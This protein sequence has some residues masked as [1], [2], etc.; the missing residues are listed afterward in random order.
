MYQ[1]RIFFN[2]KD[3]AERFGSVTSLAMCY[4]TIIQNYFVGL[5]LATICLLFVYLCYVQITQCLPNC[6]LLSSVNEDNKYSDNLV[7]FTAQNCDR[8]K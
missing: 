7:D 2:S 6:L 1:G 5:H 4:T 8:I 3:M